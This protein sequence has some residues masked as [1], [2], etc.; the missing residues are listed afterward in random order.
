MEWLIG[1]AG[2]SCIAAAA[3][4]KKSLSLSGALA[5]VVL[6]TAMYG[7]ASAAWFGTLIA[8]FVSSSMLSKLKAKRKEEAEQG[9][10]K[11]SRRDWGQVAANGGLGLLAC[12]ANAVWASELWWFL[13]LGVMA[14]V[15]SDTWATEIGGLS[16]GEPRFILTGKRVAPGTSGGITKLGLAASL[17]GGAF[18]GLVGGGLG[19]WGDADQFAR[20]WMAYSLLGAASG[21]LGALID[22]VLGATA[23][24]MYRCEHCGK[25]VE[26]PV[27]CGQKARQ[28][29]GLRF[30]SNDAVNAL[31]S[32]V[33]GF[34]CLGFSF[35]L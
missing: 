29:R 7:L 34:I 32:L 15:N 28:I 8:F 6:G 11:G 13:F 22:S 10:A 18:I 26:K 14:T 12:I 5:A 17:L 9:Y 20:G 27:H 31:S 30:M 1:L 24:V 3:Y 2:S 21:L 16:K 25:T 23:Q 19:E 35:L 33:G 4:W